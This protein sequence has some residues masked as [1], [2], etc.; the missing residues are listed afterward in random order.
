M[1]FSHFSLNIYKD[2]KLLDL[3]SKNAITTNWETTW[4][5]ETYTNST[6][7]DQTT[8]QNTTT[9][10]ASNVA[11]YSYNYSNYIADYANGNNNNATPVRICCLI[12][13]GTTQMYS[14]WYYIGG[15]PAVN[16]TNSY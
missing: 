3:S 14:Q 2:G 6:W 9:L 15:E 11:N 16:V 13:E 4:Y 10:S 8:L 12:T 5:S 1:Q 7:S